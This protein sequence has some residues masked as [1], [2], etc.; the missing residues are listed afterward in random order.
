MNEQEWLLNFE[1]V[2]VDAGIRIESR[3]F[4]E[5]SIPWCQP[6]SDGWRYH[7]PQGTGPAG[8]TGWFV[9]LEELP[10]IDPVMA[11]EHFVRVYRG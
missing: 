11:A 6:H 7:F 5:V 3:D 9:N 8:I 2:I 4:G 1:R 10:N